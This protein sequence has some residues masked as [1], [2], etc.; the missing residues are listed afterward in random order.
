VEACTQ[1]A[2]RAAPAASKLHGCRT[3]LTMHGRG[4]GEDIPL[5]VG[6]A[7]HVEGTDNT[8]KV[9]LPG[10]SALIVKPSVR[11]ADRRYS[12]TWGDTVVVTPAGGRRLGRRAQAVRIA[13]A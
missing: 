2:E 6:S 1:A 11:T 9:P 4:M 5:V 7:A 8:L 12:V 3:S 13:G 10:N